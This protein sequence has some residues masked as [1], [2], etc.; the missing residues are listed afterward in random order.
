[1]VFRRR[2]EGLQFALI[3]ANGRW[4]LPKGNIERDETPELT[5]L[6]EIAEET[7][8][9]IDRLRIVSQLPPVD[10]A[11]RWQGALV[12][13]TVHNYLVQL[14]GDA[15]FKPQLSEIEAAEWFEPADARRTISF[16]NS[17]ETLETAIAQAEAL[18]AAS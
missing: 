10:Y 7:G 11:F 16:K 8:L 13:K 1:V 17:R 9:P 6:R 5:A 3:K 18:R 15:P 2:P 12:F 14:V 4:A